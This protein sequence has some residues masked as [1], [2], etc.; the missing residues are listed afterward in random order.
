LAQQAGIAA[1]VQERQRLARELHDSVTQLLYSQILFSGASLKVLRQGNADLAQQH[2]TRIESAAQQ[3]LKEMRLL[4]YELRPSNDLDEGL[5]SALERRL[6]A[7]EKRTG[8]NAKLIAGGDLQTDQATA[9]ALYRIAEE[10]LNNTLKHAGASNVLVTLQGI[11]GEFFLEVSDDGAGFDPGAPRQGG[12]G[13]NN[14]RERVAGLG[15]N[16][17]IHSSPGAGARV[18]VRLQK[19]APIAQT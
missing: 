19:P 11:D 14:M 8:I 7:V 15:G 16:L 10:A 6:E 3:A 5:A 9:M 13:L 2:L 17:E 18:C 4:V 1:V 12:M